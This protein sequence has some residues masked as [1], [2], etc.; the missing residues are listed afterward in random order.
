MSSKSRKVAISSSKIGGL[1]DK[2][3][4]VFERCET[5]TV[6]E[7]EDGEVENV[8]VVKNPG[9]QS[10][11]CLRLIGIL[12]RKG[13]GSILVGGMGRIAFKI[14]SDLGIGVYL[15]LK[16]VKVR[17]SLQSYLDNELILLTSE[18]VCNTILEKWSMW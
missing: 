3:S 10:G 4:P 13:V 2:C 1:D 14:C 12:N 17:V 7:L 18:M 11:D 6:V 8:E 5:S 16:A 15:G 9:Y